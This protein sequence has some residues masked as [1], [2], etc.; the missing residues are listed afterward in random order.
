MNNLPTNSKR[1]LLQDALNHG[2]LKLMVDARDPDV[3]LPEE[4]RS[5]FAV[6]LSLSLKFGIP[7]QLEEDAIRSPL[8][9]NGK[10]FNCV[11]PW[12]AIWQAVQGENV[13]WF[14]DAMPNEIVD[15]FMSE[16][17]KQEEAKTAASPSVKFQVFVT[18]A[19]ELSPPK[20]GHLSI[21]K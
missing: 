11:L 17:K 13:W 9:F 12:K 15:T 6:S 18:I 3:Q 21:V 20:T 4:L 7:V 2:M 10:P 16:V 19:P 1:Q 14:P 8:S 5:H